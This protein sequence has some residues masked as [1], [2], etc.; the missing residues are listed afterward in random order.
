MIDAPSLLPLLLLGLLGLV[1]PLCSGLLKFPLWPG[2]VEEAMAFYSRALALLD[3]GHA[4]APVVW[5]NRAMAALKLGLLERAEE[6]C[7]RAIA[8]DPGYDKARLRRGMTRF[9]RGR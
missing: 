3:D 4:Q 7:S 9:K 5:A 8:L 1:A 6:D 2:Q